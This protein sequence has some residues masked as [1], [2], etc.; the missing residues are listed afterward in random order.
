STIHDF[1]IILLTEPWFG[2][3]GNNQRG[4]VAGP[5]WTPTLP[6]Q[7]IPDEITPR[8]MAY[9]RRRNDFTVML[10]SDLAKDAD[11]QILQ[12]DQPPHT[13]VIVANIYNQRA[14]DDPCSWTLDRLVNTVLP[15]NLPLVISGDW[16]LHHPLW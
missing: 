9:V 2:N 12:I 7:P 10:R 15:Y 5:G 6:V 16:N 13:P 3:I 14:G 4:P 8:V 11:I 1:D